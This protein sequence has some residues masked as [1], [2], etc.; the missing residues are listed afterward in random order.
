[1]LSIGPLEHIH[2]ILKLCNFDHYLPIFLPPPSPEPLVTTL[3]RML[4]LIDDFDQMATS[5]WEWVWVLI[6]FQMEGSF[7]GLLPCFQLL[8]ASYSKAS[9][10]LKLSMNT[11]NEIPIPVLAIYRPQG[12]VRLALKQ[13]KLPQEL[14]FR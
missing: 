10:E 8:T 1:M 9:L 14:L 6:N 5:F 2:F 13:V 7:S 3:L 12:N 4:Q 11:K